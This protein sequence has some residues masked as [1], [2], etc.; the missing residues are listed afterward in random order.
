MVDSVTD[1]VADR[2]GSGHNG[3]ELV[4]RT[5]EEFLLIRHNDAGTF[6]VAVIGEQNIV[7]PDHVRPALSHVTKPSFIVNVP[8]K[9]MWSGSAIGLVH[10]TPAAFGTMGEIWKAARTG[11]V[12]GYR[13]QTH[14]FFEKAIRNHSKVHRVTRLY[15][16]VFVAHR[17]A[18]DSLTI[19]LVEAYNMSAEDVRNARQRYGKFDIA[20]KTSSYGAI[21]PEARQ[22]AESMGAEALIFGEM[23]RRLAR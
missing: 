20:V 19:A 1:W 18:R 15:D 21:T 10:A 12:P 6:T 22:A 11:Y 13:N 9:A 7:L 4:G 14:D 16:A 23:L 17:G 3:L 8:S 5:D 2:I